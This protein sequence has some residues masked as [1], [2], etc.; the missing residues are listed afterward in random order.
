MMN[1]AGLRYSMAAG[2]LP[3]SHVY[4]SHYNTTSYNTISGGGGNCTR[5]SLDVCACHKY[6]LSKLSGWPVGGMLSPEVWIAGDL[7]L[8]VV[9]LVLAAPIVRRS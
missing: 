6:V 7:A 9:R 4:T 2:Y 8:S 1:V 3:A 5:S